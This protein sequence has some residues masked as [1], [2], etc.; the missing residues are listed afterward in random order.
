MAAPD[1]SPMS[2]DSILLAHGSGG[3]LMRRLIDEVF[4]AGSV[5]PGRTTWSADLG[6]RLAGVTVPTGGAPVVVFHDATYTTSH[7]TQVPETVLALLEYYDTAT[8]SALFQSMRA[9]VLTAGATGNIDA[10]TSVSLS[11]HKRSFT[12]LLNVPS[13]PSG[14]GIAP[15][16]HH[17]G[18]MRRSA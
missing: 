11:T 1:G 4:V 16:L 9:G 17:Y 15:H 7:V 8:N 6:Y 5:L 18:M 13:E 2:Q 12:L 3:T 14:G 10:T